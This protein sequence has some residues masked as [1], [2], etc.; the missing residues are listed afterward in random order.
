MNE[1]TYKTSDL[2]LATYLLLKGQNL[3]DIKKLNQKKSVFIFVGDCSMEADEFYNGEGK[4]FLQYAQ[5]M[6]DLKSRMY[7]TME[8]GEV[9]G[10]A[11][12]ENLRKGYRL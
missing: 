4:R 6:R 1:D 3:A 11:K 9:D 10:E 12:P 2:Y 7:A 5:I 8:Q